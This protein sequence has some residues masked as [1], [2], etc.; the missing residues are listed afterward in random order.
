MGRLFEPKEKKPIIKQIGAPLVGSLYYLVV[1]G[2]IG[3]IGLAIWASVNAPA[4]ATPNDPSFVSNQTAIFAVIL[5]GLTLTLASSIIIPKVLLKFEVESQL[6]EL[7]KSSG[8][9]S[10]RKSFLSF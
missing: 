1:L 2:L 6:S 7:K 4:S 5:A 10:K 8:K 9:N 3:L